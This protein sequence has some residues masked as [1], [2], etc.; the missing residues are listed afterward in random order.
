M[1]NDVSKVV[2]EN[3]L[4]KALA[5]GKYVA[6]PDAYVVGKG[7]EYVQA[8]LDAQKKGMSGKKVVITL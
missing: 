4:P 3:F 8:G 6:A 7:L 5:E 1:K 2:Y